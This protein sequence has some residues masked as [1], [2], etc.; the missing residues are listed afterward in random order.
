MLLTDK[1]RV[2]ATIDWLD[3]TLSE[4]KQITDT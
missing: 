3:F 1:S 2:M 4:D